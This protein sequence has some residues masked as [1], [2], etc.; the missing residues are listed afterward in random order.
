MIA[1]SG[2]RWDD[3][4]APILTGQPT[5]EFDAADP[6]VANGNTKVIPN[7]SSVNSCE[8]ALESAGFSYD[9]VEVRVR[10][11]R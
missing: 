2:E 6:V 3:A 1:E 4:M 10:L 7:C 11:Q 8:S 9:T 5:A